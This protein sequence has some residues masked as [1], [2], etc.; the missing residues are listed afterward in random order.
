MF[1]GD[2]SRDITSRHR[3]D[4][5]FDTVRSAPVIVEFATHQPSLRRRFL[6]RAQ[7]SVGDRDAVPAAERGDPNVVPR[8]RASQEAAAADRRVRATGLDPPAPWHSRSIRVVAQLF[9]ARGADAI[10]CQ[11]L[12]LLCC[13]GLLCGRVPDRRPC[14]HPS[15]HSPVPGMGRRPCA[16]SGVRA[17]APGTAAVPAWRHR[18]SDGHNL[19][20]TRRDLLE[21]PCRP[22]PQHPNALALLFGPVCHHVVRNARPNGY[23]CA[24]RLHA[25]RGLRASALCRT[26]PLDRSPMPAVPDSR[27]GCAGTF[28]PSFGQAAAAAVAGSSVQVRVSAWNRAAPCP[29]TP[30]MSMLATFRMSM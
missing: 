27:W 11:P 4:L 18:L 19:D 16:G 8:L 26:C 20:S 24:G 14:A 15:R 9:R 13:A 3:N 5:E 30:T 17:V 10:L 1:H 2:V 7:R 28:V 12:R 21:C 25:G 23:G 6:V 29:R 22:A